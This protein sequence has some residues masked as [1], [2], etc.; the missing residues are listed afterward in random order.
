MRLS[1]VGT[2]DYGKCLRAGKSLPAG[3]IIAKWEGYIVDSYDDVPANMKLKALLIDDVRFLV[4]TNDCMYAN[5]S[6]DPNC[7]ITDNLE[8]MT[9]KPVKA[10]E[11]L[12]FDYAL[13]ENG[14][15]PMEWQPEWSFT[16]HCGS[17]KCRGIID[18]YFYP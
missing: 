8:I 12:C 3:V 7:E 1:F 2:N 13:C 5:H 10:F 11:E 15:D 18:R 16:C 4:P 17:S 14:D 9:V 6:C